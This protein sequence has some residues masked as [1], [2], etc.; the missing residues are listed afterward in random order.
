MGGTEERL[1]TVDAEGGRAG[2]TRDQVLPAEEMGRP[3]EP[4]WSQGVLVEW[5]VLR[6]RGE[7]CLVNCI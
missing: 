3:M 7:F 1:G 6:E 2:L 5:Q 4:L